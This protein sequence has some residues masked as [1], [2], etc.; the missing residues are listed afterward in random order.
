MLTKWV[1]L[2][3]LAGAGFL[4]AQPTPDVPVLAPEAVV[5][6]QPS[7]GQPTPN[8]RPSG[9]IDIRLK[10]ELDGTLS[11]RESIFLD[12]GK[13]MARRSPLR[14]SAGE[15]RDRVFG[16]HD[17]YVNGNGDA[18]V[19][20][21][22]LIIEV[23]EGTS[24]IT[25]KVDGAVA[26]VG[27]ELEVRWQLT[28]GWDTKIPV[29]RAG[30]SAPEAPVRVDCL[31]GALGS[32]T[33]CG[34][35]QTDHGQVLRVRHGDLPPGER[36]DLA[37]GLPAKRTS[38]TG[39]MVD[40]VPVNARFEENKTVASAFAFT[41]VSGIGLGGLTLLLVGGFALLWFVRGRDAKALATD[42]GPVE[43]LLRDG[44]RV[45]F[46]SPD[47][48]LPGQ[49]GTVV[50]EHVDVADVSATVVDLAVRNYLWIAEEQT[51]NGLDW[52][53][54][55]RNPADDALTGY[56]RAVYQTLLPDGVDSARLSELADRTVTLETVR[57]AMYADVV[58]RHWFA[59][60]P[61][62][63][64]SRWSWI[65]VGLLV[66]GVIA[67]LVLAVTVGHALIGLALVVGGVA[68]ALGARFVPARTHRGSVLVGQVRGLRDYLHGADPAN[69]PD[70]DREM[71]FSRSL[72]YAIVL[73]Q[74]EDWLGRFAQLDPSADG[75]P[76]LYWY[77]TAEHEERSRDLQRFSRT[78]PEFLS[79]LADVLAGSGHL[80][81][82]R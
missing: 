3:V 73:G 44:D 69:L 8:D 60:R 48:V 74:A 46:A 19:E 67:T 30:F 55:R 77:G 71:V 59:R 10:V 37:V 63:E 13:K 64:R 16:V 4:A 43:V 6:E 76:G 42:V 68:L 39:D 12:P 22:E 40:T 33:R 66:L 11:V 79:R 35:A 18:R 15:D 14:I 52:H 57:T 25:Y 31:A 50:D 20:N 28:S 81:S 75:T 49:I 26:A 65:G 78:F 27:E 32:Q 58:E 51:E 70:A 80:R 53:L 36:I 34:M 2:P 62:T 1:V 61:D 23:G 45:A 21:D 82:Q 56:E 9:A 41:P 17:A 7:A 72:P 54:M 5:A 38:E 47:G 24:E 29:L